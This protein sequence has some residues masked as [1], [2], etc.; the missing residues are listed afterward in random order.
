MGSRLK[1]LGSNSDGD[2]FCCDEFVIV[3]TSIGIE[4]L[5]KIPIKPGEFGMAESVVRKITERAQCM[6]C[7]I[8]L[9]RQFWVDS[10][11]SAVDIESWYAL[12]LGLLEEITWTKN[13]ND[14]ET[15]VHGRTS[16]MI[17]NIPTKLSRTKLIELLDIHCGNENKRIDEQ[18][19]RLESCQE[20]M[21]KFDFVYLPINFRIVL[22]LGYAC[23][24]FTRSVGV[25]RFFRCFQNFGWKS[26]DSRKVC[27]MNLARV[28][29]KH[30]IVRHSEN[31]YFRCD[32]DEFLAV[33]LSLAALDCSLSAGATKNQKMKAKA[34]PFSFSLKY[35]TGLFFSSPPYFPLPLTPPS[36]SPSPV[37]HAPFVHH[38]V[39]LHYLIM[40]P[41]LYFL[42][43]PPPPQPDMQSCTTTSIT[44][45][46][47][48]NNVV[49]CKGS[50]PF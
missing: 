12:D 33:M 36:P 27:E 38:F 19:L 42:Q 43:P 4:R 14:D 32:T 16:A 13:E 29:G 37:V 50:K 22:N 20:E 9:S 49:T 39:P 26:F 47:T 40:K 28:Q 31:S 41:F 48:T 5:E 15:E 17:K 35:N 44:T 21:Y 30:G 11:V 2:Q 7:F 10:V 34:R 8:E 6:K 18:Y 1:R 46:T 24:N 23:V 45:T 3:K 25:V